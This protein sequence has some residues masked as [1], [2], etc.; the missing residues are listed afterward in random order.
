MAL[1]GFVFSLLHRA[2]DLRPNKEAPG[3]SLDCQIPRNSQP[4]ITTPQASMTPSPLKPA[5]TKPQIYYTPHEV[6][7]FHDR[8]IIGDLWA[9]SAAS[10]CGVEGTF[11]V[12]LHRGLKPKT[13]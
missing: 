1:L 10:H 12:S 8:R 7:A 6:A 13:L 3:T 5:S 4:R 2:L 11:N 9:N